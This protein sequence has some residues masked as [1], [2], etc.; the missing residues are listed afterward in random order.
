MIEET[1][2]ELESRLSTAD[3]MGEGQKAELLGLLASLRSEVAQLS[4]TH[5]DEARS[6]AGF[7]RVSAHEAI[8]K[9]RDPKLIELAVTG[10]ETSVAGFEESHPKLVEVVNRICVTLSNL[11]I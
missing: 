4:T 5:G 1:I 6:I 3:S 9:E 11:G 8:R 7:T 2:K 10:L